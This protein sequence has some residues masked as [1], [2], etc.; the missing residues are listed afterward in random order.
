MDLNG[1]DVI[2]AA[3]EA[4]LP[5]TAGALVVAAKSSRSGGSRPTS[6]S[7]SRAPSRPV[8]RTRIVRDAAAMGG[9]SGGIFDH[10]N[11]A[12]AAA[13]AAVEDDVLAGPSRDPDAPPLLLD[14]VRRRGLGLNTPMRLC[15]SPPVL[16]SER[17][18][19]EIGVSCR[20]RAAPHPRRLLPCQSPTVREAVLQ[21]PTQ[22]SSPSHCSHGHL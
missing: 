6:Q 19:K 11:A 13:L 18:L 21:L 1:A 20:G 7:R 16:R 3:D 15:R 12:V 14:Q 2:V 5:T 9:E 4:E 8:S 22:S 17:S 10:P